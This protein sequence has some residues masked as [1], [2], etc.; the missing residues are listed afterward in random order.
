MK[1]AEE[2]QAVSLA[3]VDRQAIREWK[4]QELEVR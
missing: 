3:N 4:Q 2:Q 1:R